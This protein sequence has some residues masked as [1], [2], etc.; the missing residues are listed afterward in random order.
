M[1]DAIEYGLPAR[2]L[3]GLAKAPRS[4]AIR[5]GTKALSYEEAHELALRWASAVLTG[6]SEQPKAIGVLAGK[7]FESYVGIL[8]ALYAGATVVP[9]HAGFPIAR[10]KRMLEISKASMVLADEQGLAV[11]T[12][13]SGTGLDI[14]VLAP[15]QRGGD[16]RLNR[17]PL[18]RRAS[19]WWP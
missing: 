5:I 9:L 19:P 6:S 1:S 18:G 12:E 10:T 16:G 8:A 2:F 14:P 4:T 15:G 7:G 11:L 17:V 13:L 3:R